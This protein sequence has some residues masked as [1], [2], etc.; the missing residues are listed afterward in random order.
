MYSS[1]RNIYISLHTSV[2]PVNVLASSPSRDFGRCA[3][4]V[5]V[6]TGVPKFG[7]D[8]VDTNQPTRPRMLSDY[9]YL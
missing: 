7:D 4:I 8:I 3:I 9:N 6:T 2:S 1:F 5:K